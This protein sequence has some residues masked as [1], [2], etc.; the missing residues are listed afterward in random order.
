[1]KITMTTNYGYKK[2]EFCCNGL[3]EL[4]L[5]GSVAPYPHS[6]HIPRFHTNAICRNEKLIHHVYVDY[7]PMCG[8]KVTGEIE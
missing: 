2:I 8:A 6:D 3:A 5:D 1:M 7:C 4:I